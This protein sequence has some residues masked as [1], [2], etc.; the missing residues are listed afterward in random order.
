MYTEE[1]EAADAK[2]IRAWRESFITRL[3]EEHPNI[4]KEELEEIFK[5]ARYK[6]FSE[7]AQKIWVKMHT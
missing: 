4:T 3:I 2:N 7:F 5:N 1:Q 6:E